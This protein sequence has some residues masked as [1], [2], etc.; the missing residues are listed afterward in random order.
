M[1][2]NHISTTTTYVMWREEHLWNIC[3][4]QRAHFSCNTVE[5]GYNAGVG[6]QL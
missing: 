1:A 5:P 6:G 4:L 3:V 2:S